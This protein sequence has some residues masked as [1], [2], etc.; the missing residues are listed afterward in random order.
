MSIERDTFGDTRNIW[1]VLERVKNN[2]DPMIK[3]AYLK[4]EICV[5]DSYTGNYIVVIAYLQIE[6]LIFNASVSLC[7]PIYFWFR[8]DQNYGDI[9]L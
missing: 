8:I 9:V 4:H 6:I 1:N 7:T 5:F 2:S 3:R